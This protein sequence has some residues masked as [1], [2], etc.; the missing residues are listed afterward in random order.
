MVKLTQPELILTATTSLS[1]RSDERVIGV[2]ASPVEFPVYTPAD[3][4]CGRAAALR[5]ARE[6]C[7]LCAA[8]PGR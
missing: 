5:V 3:E 1:L 2:A 7:L 4:T 8:S 6:V